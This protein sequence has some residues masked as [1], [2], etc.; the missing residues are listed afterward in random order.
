MGS[1]A[2]K[3]RLARR[4]GGG[5]CAGD[6]TKDRADARRDA[7]H[8]RSCGNGYKPRHQSILNEVLASTI[9]PNSQRPNQISDP[10]HLLPFLTESPPLLV[11]V[12]P[13]VDT[14]TL[15]EV[16]STRNIVTWLLC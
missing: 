5:Q 9:P 11:N 16:L 7:R 15:G 1:P 8:D 13:L 12:S 10:Y 4:R 3:A 6:L 14:M 2:Q